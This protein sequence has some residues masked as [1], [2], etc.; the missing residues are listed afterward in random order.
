MKNIH[1]FFQNLVTLIILFYE[2]NLND[3]NDYFLLL[4]IFVS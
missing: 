1:V 2:S 3:L 4:S